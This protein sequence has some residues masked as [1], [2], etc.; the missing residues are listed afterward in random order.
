MEVHCQLLKPRADAAEF[1]QP[2][3]ALLGDAPAT[4]RHAVEPDRRVVAGQFVVL[5]RNHRLDLLTGQPVPHTLDAVALVAGELPGLAATPAPLPPAS[6]Q[7]RDRLPD[8]RFRPRRFVDLSRG[9]FDGE[10]SART[11]SD[12]VELR[13][14]P[15][16]AAAQCVVGGFVGVPPETFLSAPAAAR[17]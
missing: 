14:N 6:D 1:L 13:S 2:A 15:A 5:V 7:E 17:A 4:V 12:H 10:G 16:A 3:D 8:D 9:D 11:V